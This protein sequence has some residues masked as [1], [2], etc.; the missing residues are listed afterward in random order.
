MVT[1]AAAELPSWSV[2]LISSGHKNENRGNFE[3]NTLKYNIISALRWLRPNRTEKSWAGLGWS[4][5]GTHILVWC[6]LCTVVLCCVLYWGC[7]TTNSRSRWRKARDKKGKSNQL[8]WVALRYHWAT[9][10]LGHRNL[11]VNFNIAGRR[12]SRRGQ[13]GHQQQ[14]GQPVVCK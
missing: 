1:V 2:L 12:K 5:M 8:N 7:G 6:S 14:R 11:T 10:S 3:Q 9:D 4:I 13:L